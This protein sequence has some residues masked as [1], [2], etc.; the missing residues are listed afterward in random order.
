MILLH[1][2]H[3]ILLG[4]VGDNVRCPV[5]NTGMSTAKEDEQAIGVLD[6]LEDGGAVIAHMKCI[7]KVM[8]EAVTETPTNEGT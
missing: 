2:N 8:D 4:R 5:C 3:P 6:V 7:Q 1:W